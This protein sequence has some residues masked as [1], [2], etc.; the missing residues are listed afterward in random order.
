MLTNITDADPDYPIPFELSDFWIP[1]IFEDT[2]L[3]SVVI[4]K[5]TNKTRNLL[6]AFQTLSGIPAKLYSSLGSFEQRLNENNTG[7]SDLFEKKNDWVHW[8]EAVA[9]GNANDSKEFNWIFILHSTPI[10]IAGWL[11]TNFHP[12]F[13]HEAFVSATLTVAGSFDPVC[14]RLGLDSSDINTAPVTGIFP[15]PLIIR[16]KL[17]GCP[18]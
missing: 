4:S 8:G 6:E 18:S 12:K 17:F 11:R 13:K 2:K 10:D 16:N 14:I 3:L 15:L 7:L 1:S 5:L 9:K